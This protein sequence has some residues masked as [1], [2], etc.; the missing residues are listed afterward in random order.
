MIVIG[1][2]GAD[3][4]LLGEASKTF[5]LNLNKKSL[6]VL[7]ILRKINLL[8]ETKGWMRLVRMFLSLRKRKIFQIFLKLLMH[9]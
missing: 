7:V 2:H 4:K 6:V 8:V 5:K 3:G 1:Q 9:Q